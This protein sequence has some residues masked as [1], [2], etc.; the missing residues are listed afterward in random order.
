[1]LRPSE[2][3]RVVVSSEF[4]FGNSVPGCKRPLTLQRSCQRRA[5]PT[6]PE[7][8]EFPVDV[9]LRLP[10]LGRGVP[11]AAASDEE[12]ATHRS[13]ALVQDRAGVEQLEVGSI[14]CG[15]GGCRDGTDAAERAVVGGA[16]FDGVPRGQRVQQRRHELDYGC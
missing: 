12:G 1:M 5:Q 7:D 16:D 15:R 10:Y 13:V 14:G 6:G 4:S 2:M 11:R 3:A 9:Y 8:F